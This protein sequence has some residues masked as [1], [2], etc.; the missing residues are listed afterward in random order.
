MRIISGRY[1]SRLIQMPKRPLIRPTK[2]RIREALFN[3]LGTS[4]I[5]ASVLDAF[6]G[7]GAFGLE[8]LSRGA[9]KVV[10]VDK[11]AACCATIGKNLEKL[12]IEKSYY[13]IMKLDTFEALNLFQRKGIR[14][15]M[16]LL[17]PPYYRG[18]AK[19]CLI[20]LDCRDILSQPCIIAVEHYKNDE[21]PEE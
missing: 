13:Q 17:D 8:A 18:I 5:H 7:S 12:E 9:D 10:F 19:K 6:A 3:I 14:F 2:D 20:Q 11:E 4:V 16:V 1:R 21:M 15:S